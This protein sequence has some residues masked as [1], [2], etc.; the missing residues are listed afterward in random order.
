MTNGG[1]ALEKTAIFQSSREME[2]QRTF[3]REKIGKRNV[4]H[5]S[6]PAWRLKIRLQPDKRPANGL[7]KNGD[8]FISKK[9]V[10]RLLHHHEQS[11]KMRNTGR[12]GF[13]KLDSASVS[14]G[15]GACHGR[16][17]GFL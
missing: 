1:T 12:I 8:R 9:I 11:G 5:V 16:C 17:D 13:R 7:R 2:G 3:P 14:M 15:G 4:Q 10:H 6:K